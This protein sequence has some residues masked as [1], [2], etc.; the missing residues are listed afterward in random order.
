M[1]DSIKLADL[2]YEALSAIIAMPHTQ[3]D[4]VLSAVAD[5]FHRRAA[6]C[7]VQATYTRKY[8]N[9]RQH[10]KL[11]SLVPGQR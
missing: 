1:T 6:E 2:P 11:F 4:E 3:D 7:Q 10:N 5:E 8:M 9:A